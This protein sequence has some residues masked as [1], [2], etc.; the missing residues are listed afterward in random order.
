VIRRRWPSARP[1]ASGRYGSRARASPAAIGPREEPEESFNARLADGRARSFGQAISASWTEGSCSSR[2]AQGHARR[3]GEDYYPHD[4]ELAAEVCHPICGE[5]PAPAFTVEDRRARSPGSWHEV[6]AG[7]RIDHEAVV[8]AVRS[9]VAAAVDLQAHT[10]CSS[11]REPPKTSSG[12]CKRWLCRSLFLK[13]ELDTVYEWSL[14]GAPVQA[15]E[16]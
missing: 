8:L 12:R 13:R 9:A 2:A 16:A 15:T 3:A 4:I 7:A 1:I 11:T 10:S 6:E 5:L 14:A